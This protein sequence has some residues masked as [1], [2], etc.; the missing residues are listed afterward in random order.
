MPIVSPT[1]SVLMSVYN[2]QGHVSLA[3]RS[4]VE[5]TFADFEF[6]IV[7]DG[8]AD[9]SGAILRAWAAV[10]ARITVIEQSNQGLT[11]S[12]N[13]LVARARGQF[14]ARMD[15]DDIAYPDRLRE[16]VVYLRAYPAVGVVACWTQIVTASGLTMT[17]NC[18]PDDSARIAAFLAEQ[19]NPFVH[20]SIMLRRDVLAQL[21][22]PYRFRNSQD[23]DLWLRLLGQ[24]EFGVVEQL[25]MIH[26]KHGAQVSARYGTRGR[27]IIKLI[28]TLHE[29]RQNGLPEGDWQVAEQ[30]I[31]DVYAAAPPDPV[32][33][34]A[35][36]AYSEAM[37][38][39][40]LGAARSR[41]RH[42]LR[43]AMAAP[44]LRAKARLHWA[45][46]LLPDPLYQAIIRW[47]LRSSQEGR[48]YRP[49]NE[50]ITPEQRRENQ[51]YWDYLHAADRMP[52]VRLTH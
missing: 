25:L 41:I 39:Q 27:E 36:D 7:D 34:A 11:Q 33:S 38:L 28:R 19:H 47:R 51:A 40:M 8:S 30:Q 50:V 21:T 22:P 3:I 18:F 31:L 46:A 23:F 5:Q 1:V 9:D 45:L 2:D 37:T 14:I 16:Q 13:T 49:L 4:I 12:L 48:F 17:C 29:R 24:T 6:L 43:Q 42:A 26:R 20:S 10:D 35:Q 52:D 44:T 32:L 15:S